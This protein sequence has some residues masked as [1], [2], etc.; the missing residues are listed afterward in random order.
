MLK[1]ACN[2]V[3]TMSGV[4]RGTHLISCQW[5]SRVSVC[6]S[7]SDGTVKCCFCLLTCQ[8]GQNDL[9]DLLDLGRPERPSVDERSP[10]VTVYH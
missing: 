2:N 7:L 3:E 4:A 1:F 5:F 8:I 10:H 9:L 6:A